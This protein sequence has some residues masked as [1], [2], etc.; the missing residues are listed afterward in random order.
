MIWIKNNPIKE[1]CSDN[2]ETVI[3]NCEHDGFIV[4]DIIEKNN[5]YWLSVQ[6][7]SNCDEDPMT[8][9]NLT[10]GWIKWR[11]KDKLLVYIY[12]FY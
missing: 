4:K 3:H 12:L 8:S 2:S 5:E 9:K 6:L 10:H 11:T 7:A 1:D